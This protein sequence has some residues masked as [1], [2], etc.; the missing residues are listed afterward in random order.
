MAQTYEG[1]THG[2]NKLMALTRSR[3]WSHHGNPVAEWC[4]DAVEVRHPPGEPD[5]IRPDKPER[6]KT[7]RRIDAVPTAAMAVGGWKLRGS[8]PRKSGRMVVMG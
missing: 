8:K 4:F 3:S 5:L 2:M 6:G 1:M 7:G